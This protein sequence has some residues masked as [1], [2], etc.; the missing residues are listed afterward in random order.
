MTQ[1]KTRGFGAPSRY[2]QGMGEMN[3]IKDHTLL[4]GR[5]VYMIIDVY[6]F[7]QLTQ[8]FRS[9][10][11]EST[12]SL[13]TDLFSGEITDSEIERVN[14]KV[15]SFKPEVVV[16][17]GGGKTLDT[18][19]VVAN[20][21]HLPV[22]IVPTTASTDAPCSAM[23]IIYKVDGTHHHERYFSKNPDIVLVDSEII[24]KAPIRYLL[25]GMGDAI[26]TYIEAR[27]NAA[28]GN[29]NYVNLGNGGG[30]QPTKAA[31]ALAKLC[32]EIIIECGVQAK[33]DAQD[34]ICSDALENVIEAN[35][36]LSGV[37]FENTG[38]AGAHALNYAFANIPGGSKL[39][40]G[41]KVAFG[42]IVQL[43][44]EN[45]DHLEL[46]KILR[47]YYDVGLPMTLED[48]GIN[49]TDEAAELIAKASMGGLW[50]SEPM[51]VDW[52]MVKQAILSADTL[53]WQFRKAFQSGI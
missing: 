23:S 20:D 26:S 4:F 48:L 24:C 8:K 28:A 18:I 49:T 14:Q 43:V 9:Q 36:L 21:L 1:S 10:Y 40:H 2:F 34:G 35:T 53:G 50:D 42:V 38:C 44:A 13:E 32:F 46:E 19:K 16:G 12:D 22:I 45:K 5:R 30:Y 25:A 27:A 11:N 15:K 6:F 51:K 17:I 29:N 33:K 7:D 37:G 52:Q 3:R 41:E 31:M 39:L 47:F